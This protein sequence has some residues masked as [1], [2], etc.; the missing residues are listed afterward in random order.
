ME[1]LLRLA[2]LWIIRLP[3]C[4]GC[5]RYKKKLRGTRMGMW[6]RDWEEN[7]IQK[8]S[9]YLESQSFRSPKKIYVT[10][11]QN[12]INSPSLHMKSLFPFHRWNKSDSRLEFKG[13]YSL[14]PVAD[15]FVL[16]IRWMPIYAKS[17]S[18]HK[19]WHRSTMELAVQNP[20]EERKT[21]KLSI[22][23]TIDFINFLRN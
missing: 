10:P 23:M 19:V 3:T 13:W 2:A 16:K 12:P 17:G 18:V 21:K 15:E 22:K 9:N 7:Q 11:D 8:Y 4:P 14:Q 5:L 20:F 6:N 1:E